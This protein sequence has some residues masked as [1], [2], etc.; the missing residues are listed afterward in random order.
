MNRTQ[1]ASRVG[2]RCF[3]T[4]GTRPTGRI[5]ALKTTSVTSSSNK[6]KMHVRLKN[7]FLETLPMRCEGRRYRLPGPGSPEGGPGHDYVVH[8]FGFLGVI[9]WNL[10][11]ICRADGTCGQRPSCVRCS[12]LCFCRSAKRSLHRGP[13]P[14][15]AALFGK[16]E[17]CF[18][19]GMTVVYF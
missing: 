11:E 6:I 19:C 3:S 14:L 15:L 1:S 5:L 7:P 12:L 13:N 4:G 10:V 16:G 17:F 2:L 8:V 18:Y 9:R